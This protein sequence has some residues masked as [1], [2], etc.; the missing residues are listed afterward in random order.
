MSTNQKQ[1]S[2]SERDSL[3]K[4]ALHKYGMNWR[5]KALITHSKFG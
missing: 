2:L 1:R 4:A 5:V 3:E